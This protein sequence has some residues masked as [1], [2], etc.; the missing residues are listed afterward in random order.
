MK[1]KDFFYLHKVFNIDEIAHFTSKGKAFPKS[2]TLFNLLAY[3]QKKGH[4]LRVRQGLYCSIPQGV[5]PVNDPCDAFLLASKMTN[6]AILGYRTALDFFGKLHSISNEF[7]YISRR[8]VTGP[9]I[10][11]GVKYQGVSVPTALRKLGQ[12][13]FG[14]ESVNRLEQKLLVTSLERTLV[15]VLDRPYLCGSWEEIWTSLES[16]EYFNLD[17][18]LHYALLL[19]N[20][21][22]IAKL[23]FFLETHQESLMIPEHYLEVLHKHR[24]LNVRY[25]DRNQKLP[26]KL[27]KRWNLIVPLH[28]I[29][30]QWEEHGNI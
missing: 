8:R 13:L 30:R 20:A 3:H 10:F 23:G 7:I 6:D 18:V 11:R 15:D 16:I 27:V 26:G 17:I 1:L 24:P 14:V 9:F 4:I 29:N 19:N 12:D 25:M 28:L 2:S 21:T 5:S 22:T